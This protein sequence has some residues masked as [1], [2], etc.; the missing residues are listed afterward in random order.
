MESFVACPLHVVLEVV[1]PLSDP[2]GSA[3]GYRDVG[4][5]IIPLIWENN[6]VLKVVRFS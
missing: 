3:S 5:V 4:V 2:Y 6:L 1:G